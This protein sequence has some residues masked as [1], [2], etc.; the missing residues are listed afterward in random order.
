MGWLGDS[1][2][3]GWL[4]VVLLARG[5]DAGS[6][7]PP[8]SSRGQP[9]EERLHPA[10]S[11]LELSPPTASGRAAFSTVASSETGECRSEQE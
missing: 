4:V 3:F 1:V 8:L 10:H 7:W 2:M 11:G 9:K 6:A 5:G